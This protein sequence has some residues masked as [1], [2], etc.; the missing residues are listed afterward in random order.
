MEHNYFYLV[1]IVLL[2]L[3]TPNLVI[4]FCDATETVFPSIIT[5]NYHTTAAITKLRGNPISSVQHFLPN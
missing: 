3:P 4:P 2:V 5:I 1:P